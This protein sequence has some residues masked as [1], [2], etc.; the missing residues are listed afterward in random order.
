MRNPELWAR[1]QSHGFDGP[2]SAPFSVKLA[3]AE[4][5]SPAFTARVIEEYR[6]FLYLTQ[7]SARQ[8]TPSQI[9]DA[10]WHMHL[11]YTRDYWDVLC[12]D[13]IGKPVHHQPCAGEEEMP[14]YRDQFAATKALYEAEFSAEPPADIW[15]REDATVQRKPQML[16]RDETGAGTMSPVFIAMIPFLVC[17][18]VALTDP[19]PLMIILTIV[20]GIM[21]FVVLFGPSQRRRPRG[22]KRRRRR[23]RDDEM[24]VD[25][26]A[27]GRSNRRS[28]D[29]GDRA[30]GDKESTGRGFFAGVFGDNDSDGGSDG[31]GCGGCGD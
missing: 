15:G 2:G 25:D 8:V 10:A 1:L 16:V 23:E 26:D 6:R 3:R 7:V 28:G 22:N 11:T 17:A 14:R 9:V 5:W 18:Y 27:G 20:T 13:V 31:G 29:D 30:R 12:P 19:S 24:W 4:R 21:F